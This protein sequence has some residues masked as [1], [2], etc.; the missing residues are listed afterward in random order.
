MNEPET[1]I[2]AM[3]SDDMATIL[4]EALTIF[5]HKYLSLL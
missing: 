4:N 1:S 3:A 2:I 5:D